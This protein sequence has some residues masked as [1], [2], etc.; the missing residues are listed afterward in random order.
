MNVVI[1]DVEERARWRRTADELRRRRRAHRRA[2]TPD[3]VAGAGRPPP[4]SASARSHV[5]VQ[6]RRRRRRRPHRATVTLDDWR[7][8]IDVNLW[9]VIHGIHSVPAA[10]PGERGRRPHREHGV[11]GRARRRRR[12]SVRTAPRSTASV[13]ISETLAAELAGD[14][15]RRSHVSVLCPGFVRTNIFTSGRN[16]PANLGKRGEGAGHRWA[17]SATR[18]IRGSSSRPRWPTTCSTPSCTTS[19]GSSPTRRCS[20]TWPARHDQIMEAAAEARD[21]ATP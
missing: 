12:A 7:W 15:A 18:S 17:T 11:A 14:E 19:S 13:A 2:P 16:R 5:I 3:S 20:T 1:A 21:R 10:P 9:G 8:M 6:Q 4:S